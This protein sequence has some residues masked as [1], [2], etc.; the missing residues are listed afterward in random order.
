MWAMQSAPKTPFSDEEIQVIKDL[1]YP[2]L[3]FTHL[4]MTDGIEAFPEFEKIMD[5]RFLRCST[6]AIQ[7]FVDAGVK[8]KGLYFDPEMFRYSYWNDVFDEKM[9]NWDCDIIS[10][11][12]AIKNVPM[13]QLFVRPDNDLKSFPG[14]VFDFDKYTVEDIIASLETKGNKIKLT[15]QVLF[16]QPQEILAEYRFYMLCEHIID[17]VTYRVHGRS[18]LVD[19][20]PTD[21]IEWV[22]K[23][24][25]SLENQTYYVVDIARIDDAINPFRI[26]EFNC[27]NCSG[28]PF[29]Q[30]EM[31]QVMNMIN[32]RG[33]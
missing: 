14:G 23:N 3:E 22:I 28:I 31:F 25:L 27:F 30:K 2:L 13:G 10:W 5:A 15:D 7:E 32:N 33:R 9:L 11:E 18:K 29:R 19:H 16:H 6:E 12:T 4:P 24:G 21:V 26:I 1:N 17:S 20:A 8:P